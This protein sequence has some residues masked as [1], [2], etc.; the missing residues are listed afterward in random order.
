MNNPGRLFEAA[1]RLGRVVDVGRVIRSRIAA[2]L[3]CGEAF[4]VFVNLHPVEL[5]DD[6]LFAPSSPLAPFASHIVLEITERAALGEI[7]GLGARI[8]RLRAMGYRIALDDL[9]AGYAGLTSV[10]QLEPDVVKLDMSLVR[11][12]QERTTQQRLVRSMIEL[13]RGMNRSVICEGV[14]TRE[15]LACL[16]SLGCELFQGYLFGKPSRELGEAV[17]PS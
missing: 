1:E 10:A 7:D 15:E 2:T 14:E 12:I 6:E 9:G 16:E 4:D 13:F 3:Q 8:E 11:N 17:W 5:T